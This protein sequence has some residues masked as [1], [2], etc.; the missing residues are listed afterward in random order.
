MIAHG[1]NLRQYQAEL[2]DDL[3]GQ[4]DKCRVGEEFIREKEK[5]WPST[6]V[7]FPAN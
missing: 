3:P 2:M 5:K 7:Y 4:V 1:I 6:T